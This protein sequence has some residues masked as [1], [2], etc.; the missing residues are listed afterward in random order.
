MI[1]KNRNFSQH[2]IL[3]DYSFNISFSVSVSYFHI[4]C[5]PVSA[6][7]NSSGVL[8]CSTLP[9]PLYHAHPHVSN[10][11]ELFFLYQHR[12]FFINY[13]LINDCTITSNAIITNNMLLHVSTFKMSSSGSLLCLAK[14]FIKIF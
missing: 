11:P 1:Q 8:V 7:F 4:S 6:Y 10:N 13:N 14:N 12:T 2:F 9:F 3:Y 5:L